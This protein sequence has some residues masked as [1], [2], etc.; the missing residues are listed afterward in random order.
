VVVAT[1]GG[2]PPFHLAVR[3]ESDAD[4]IAA[5]LTSLAADSALIDALTT[6]SRHFSP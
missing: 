6:L 5:E 1:A 2:A 4:A 3:R